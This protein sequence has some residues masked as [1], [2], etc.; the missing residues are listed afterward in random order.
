MHLTYIEW[1]PKR[2]LQLDFLKSSLCLYVSVLMRKEPCHLTSR[3]RSAEGWLQ[4]RAETSD[5]SCPDFLGF[6]T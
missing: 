6:F 1:F 4:D 2:V 5:H 3:C